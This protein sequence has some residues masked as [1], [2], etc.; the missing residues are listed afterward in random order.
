MSSIIGNGDKLLVF[1]VRMQ[2]R[3]V[4]GDEREGRS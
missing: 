1:K 2:Q 3:N 4:N